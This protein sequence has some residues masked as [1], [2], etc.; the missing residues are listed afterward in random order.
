[1]PHPCIF[2]DVDSTRLCC[3]ALCIEMFRTVIMG[4]KWRSF[5]KGLARVHIEHWWRTGSVM[6]VLVICFSFTT[7]SAELS[8]GSREWLAVQKPG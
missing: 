7:L 3:A 4:R 6:S 2:R 1:M 8:Q 5:Q